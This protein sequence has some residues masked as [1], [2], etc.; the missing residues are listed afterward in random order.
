[1]LDRAAADEDVPVDVMSRVAAPF[2]IAVI[3][4]LLGIA[5][6]DTA[7]FAR[8]GAFI[9]QSLD[10]VRSPAQA[11]ELQRAERDLFALLSRLLDE[12]T[13]EPRD[14][15]LTV[16][17]RARAEG[18]ASTGDALA[19]AELLLI[20]GFETTVNLIGNGSRLPTTRRG[21]TGCR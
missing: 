12:R 4:T 19:T 11:D 9:G 10:G 13:V 17:A 14:D 21:G 1:M 6:V 15:V 2:P 5:D 18:L 16:I 8:I 20:A 3:A 7:R